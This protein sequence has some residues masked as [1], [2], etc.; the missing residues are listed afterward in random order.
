MGPPG[1]EHSPRHRPLP[2]PCTAPVPP[3]LPLHLLRG[4]LHVEPQDLC[5]LCG[6]STVV[7]P[8]RGTEGSGPGKTSNEIQSSR[9]VPGVA[10]GRA[11]LGALL[12]NGRVSIFSSSPESPDGSTFDC[13]VFAS[14]SEQECEEIVGRIG[15]GRV[16]GFSYH[17]SH[18]GILGILGFDLI[19]FV[20]V[21]KLKK[22]FD[23]LLLCG[24]S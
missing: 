11:E 20:E 15:K 16:C 18:H 22:Y 19:T 8:A 13:L 14:S 3:S 17:Q 9:R 7:G 21:T 1:T 24:F 2:V 4:T 10:E 12:D 5:L 6:V 23:I